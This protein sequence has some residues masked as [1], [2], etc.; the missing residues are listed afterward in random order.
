LFIAGCGTSIESR[1]V[2]LPSPNPAHACCFKHPPDDIGVPYQLSK[3]QF[4]IA[5]SQPAVSGGSPKYTLQLEMVPDADRRFGVFV[6]P[7]LFNK[8]DFSVTLNS[9][10]AVSAL[11]QTSQE[12]ITP[13]IAAIGQFVGSVV[14]AAATV[15][16]GLLAESNA[17]AVNTSIYNQ[18][19][20]R[21]TAL[22][23]IPVDTVVSPDFKMTPAYRKTAGDILARLSTVKPAATTAQADIIKAITPQ[24]ATKQDEQNE[25]AVLTV[26]SNGNAVYKA[27]P[28]DKDPAGNDWRPAVI[29]TKYSTAAQPTTIPQAPN[30]QFGWKTFAAQVDFA[31]KNEDLAS[32]NSFSE[33]VVSANS[34][35]SAAK[36]QANEKVALRAAALTL[37]Q[38]AKDKVLFETTF[39][40]IIGPSITPKT[41]SQKIYAHAQDDLKQI[42]DLQPTLIGV[43]EAEQV[44]IQEK[45]EKLTQ[46]FDETIGAGEEYKQIRLLQKFLAHGPPS[47][48]NAGRSSPLNEYNSARTQLDALENAITMKLSTFASTTSTTPSAKPSDWTPTPVDSAFLWNVQREAMEIAPPPSLAILVPKDE[49]SKDP[50]ASE[51]VAARIVQAKGPNP[52]DWP[53][54]VVVL[55]KVKP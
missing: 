5:T 46:D 31:V 4:T 19:N 15:T 16:G 10:G 34:L 6:K 38:A 36:L 13:T 53:K 25:F 48:Q 50:T 9:N 35:S 29:D 30:I 7:G 44:T 43:T 14:G 41:S 52:A 8:A 33:Y 18:L 3:P 45:I 2:V 27:T 42:A 23:A 32:L 21:F 1:R 12:Q 22:Q 11:S 40:T 26:I 51:S 20:L 17:V 47:A 49:V 24:G 37:A 55:D 39:P 54:N 28:A